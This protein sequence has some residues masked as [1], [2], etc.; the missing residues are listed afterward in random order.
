MVHGGKRSGAGR[1][2][3][4]GQYQDSTQVMRIPKNMVDQ[5]Q[6]YVRTKGYQ[7]PLYSNSVSAGF[8][9]PADDHIEAQLDLNSHLVKNP[10]STFFVRVSGESM[11][12]VGIFPND[13]L[14]VDR[15]INAVDGKIVIAVVDGELTVKRLK[16][17]KGALFLMPE[18]KDFNPII[19]KELQDFSIWGVVT[20]VIH[21]L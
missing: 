8:P 15:S 19:V 4:S 14:I 20:N 6:S 2:K 13:I 10:A 9:S 1:P 16:I 5:V 12:D 21:A 18:N 7:L 11:K 17:E 3:G